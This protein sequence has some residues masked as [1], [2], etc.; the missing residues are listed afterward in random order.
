M[1]NR[2]DSVQRYAAPDTTDLEAQITALIMRAGL[3][4]RQQHR[5]VTVRRLAQAAHCRLISTDES[6]RLPGL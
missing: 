2:L 3:R 1:I 4:L 6:D 5:A